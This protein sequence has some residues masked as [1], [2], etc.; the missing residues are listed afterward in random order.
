EGEVKLE[1]KLGG[2]L[3]APVAKLNLFGNETS[4][5]N[6]SSTIDYAGSA[7]NYVVNAK[8]YAGDEKK[9]GVT[10]E[11][12]LT[13][14]LWET[15]KFIINQH[16]GKVDI[17]AALK[18]DDKS[19]TQKVLALKAGVDNFAVGPA[20]V[21]ADIVI[22]GS[23][24]GTNVLAAVLTAQNVAVN[25][26]GISDITGKVEYA[27][28]RV[29][30][31]DWYSRDGKLKSALTLNL[32]DSNIAFTGQC[33]AD[34][35]PLQMFVSMLNP[36]LVKNVGGMVDNTLNLTGTAERPVLK[37]DT[38]VREGSYDKQKFVC[39]AKSVLVKNIVTSQ[40]NFIPTGGKSVE[41]NLNAVYGKNN[42]LK[43]KAELD[44]LEAANIVIEGITLDSVVTKKRVVINSGKFNIFNGTVLIAEGTEV[45]FDTANKTGSMKGT[46]VINS[47]LRNISLVQQL[48]LYG[49]AAF[50]GDWVYD[51][52]NGL[53]FE[54]L[55]STKR[56]WVNEHNFEYGN[57]HFAYSKNMIMFMPVDNSE[58][59]IM[60]ELEFN[61]LPEVVF[62]DFAVRNYDSDVVSV[63]GTIGGKQNNLSIQGKTLPLGT[64]TALLN[65]KISV[66]GDTVFHLIIS[67]TPELMLLNGRL[68]SNNGTIANLPFERL[69]TLFTI[70]GTELKV[71]DLYISNKD[72]YLFTGS[73]NMQLA[74]GKDK[75][76]GITGPASINV[77]LANGNL[78]FL[79]NIFGIVKKSDGMIDGEVELK[80]DNLQRTRVDGN[81]RIT[82]C[83]IA[84]KDV[85]NQ[86]NGLNVELTLKDDE[87]IVDHG[88]ARIGKGELGL[89]GKVELAGFGINRYDI[90]L[91]TLTQTGIALNVQWLAIPKSMF[92]KRVFNVPST[93][94]A[95]VDVSLA[96]T[97]S[98]PV[99]RGLVELNNASFIYP[100]SESAD[101]GT[102]Q[103]DAA[104]LDNTVWDLVLKTGQNVWYKNENIDLQANGQ[105]AFANRTKDLKVNG[106]FESIRGNANY[107]GRSFDIRRAR[108]EIVNNETYLEATAETEGNIMTPSGTEVATKVTMN[109]DRT[110]IA[111]IKP[112]FSAQDYP[113]LPEEKVVLY[114][115][116]FS[117]KSLDMQ[118][119]QTKLRT[120]VIRM[121]GSSIAAPFMET[122]AAP[123]VNTGIVDKV[124]VTQTVS[125]QATTGDSGVPVGDDAQSVSF[126]DFLN[127]TKTT[128]EKIIAP[129]LAIGYSMQFADK[130]SLWHEVELSYKWKQLL[131]KGTIKDKSI[132]FS[133]DAERRIS[134]EH[135]ERFGGWEEEK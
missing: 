34:N 13:R 71:R 103:F 16:G 82:N 49:K 10:F 77:K 78:R 5:G 45:G 119:Q 35:L 29:N 17:S 56:F 84:L 76:K 73:G 30:L 87:V 55:A 95:I 65:Q 94:E 41:F 133:N 8:M 43:V 60:G 90:K 25:K 127:G 53:R 2:I 66:T 102:A 15:K 120:E 89:S 115:F 52:V 85:F 54:A 51:N 18:T 79:K 134:I 108:L 21:S 123:L 57:I 20:K 46:Y 32:N 80:I 42:E 63:K 131:F 88:H 107:L 28:G 39:T 69:N 113:N 14:D 111:E 101:T 110:R 132:F 50:R 125:R 135:V 83:N 104:V 130:L 74:S 121:F 31:R 19:G 96:G 38:S 6:I 105:V 109:I 72:L 129:D 86:I 1:G 92:F 12:R 26:Y 58:Y 117:E 106:L 3:T 7:D 48:N 126:A 22:N 122:I 70:Q 98:A 81:L 61:N 11:C 116:G 68:E 36:E 40:V 9:A 62:K 59:Q 97:A 33:I 91:K 4:L 93:G 99:I 64:L 24:T 100:P 44:R 128:F 67:G 47:E 23:L 75:D 27:G 118:G 124:K 112:R 37:I 114:L